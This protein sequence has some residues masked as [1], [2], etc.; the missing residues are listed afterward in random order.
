[1][2]YKC[3]N[4][5]QPTTPCLEYQGR[6]NSKGYGRPVFP[7]GKR[8]GYRPLLHR[9]IIEQVDGPIPEGM[10]VL[11]LCD[12]PPCFRYDHLA[13]GTHSDNMQDCIAKGRHR[14][15]AHLGEDNGTAKLTDEQVLEIRQRY[16]VENISQRQLGREYGIS[17]V[18]VGKIVNR[19]KWKH[20]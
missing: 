16:A 4:P 19:E 13:I 12:N 7:T 11:H 15:I 2:I 10:E 3:E 17:G 6:R 18:W 8:G 9:W 1:M 5:T 14:Y 20:L